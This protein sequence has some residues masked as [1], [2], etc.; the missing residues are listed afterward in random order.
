MFANKTVYHLTLVAYDSK[1][2]SNKTAKKKQFYL[3][4]LYHL[5]NCTKKVKVDM[6]NDLNNSIWLFD[7]CTYS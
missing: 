7:S 6:S 1:E 4:F 2:T 3:V 5:M